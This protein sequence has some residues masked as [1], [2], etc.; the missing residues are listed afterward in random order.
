MMIKAFTNGLE[1]ISTKIPW[2]D[3]FHFAYYRPIIKNELSLLERKPTRVL[4]I[5]GGAAPYSPWFL[6]NE[7]RAKI[8]V[9]ENC[10]LRKIHGENFLT[11]RAINVIMLSHDGTRVNVDGYDLIVVAKQVNPKC[12]VL[13]HILSNA[14]AGTE[15]LVRTNKRE[16]LRHSPINAIKH[17]RR[18]TSQTYRYRLL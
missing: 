18:R 1:A 7:T 9:I 17:D 4:F 16:Q 12:R 11:K 2:I 8:T 14:D 13:D 15:V 3:R 10:R 6:Y 5:G